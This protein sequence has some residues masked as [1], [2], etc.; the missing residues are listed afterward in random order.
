MTDHSR[1]SKDFFA[2]VK[3]E[4]AKLPPGSDVAGFI[5]RKAQELQALFAE[6]VTRAREDASQ[7]AD[8]SPSGMS[9]L[10]MPDDEAGEDAPPKDDSSS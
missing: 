2:Q 5:T 9:P 1:S 10:R 6:E 8:F 4:V 3:D 7:E